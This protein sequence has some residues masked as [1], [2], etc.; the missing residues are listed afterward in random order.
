VLQAKLIGAAI[1]LA[2]LIGGV[3]AYGHRQYQRGEQNARAD[4]QAAL[5]L[6]RAERKRVDWQ[7]R[8][9][10]ETRIAELNAQAARERRGA[11]I[12]CVRSAASQVR[13]GPDS[14]G[15][16]AGASGEPAVRVTEDLRPELVRVGSSCE[17]L[18]QQL[19]AIKE[20]QEALE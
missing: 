8:Q 7:V 16:T 12:H 10:Y 13:T 9:S 3:L 15:P 1:L 18:R 11:A 14:A 20:R 17:Q 6:E 4:M 19:I 5:E 2:L